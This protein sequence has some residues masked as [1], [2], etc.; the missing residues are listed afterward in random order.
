LEAIVLKKRL[1]ALLLVL[2]FFVGFAAPAAYA[3]QDTTALQAANYL[4]SFGL[5]RGTDRGYELERAGTRAEALVMLI[6]LLGDEDYALA[7]YHWH[8]FDDVPAWA[9]LYVGYA[10]AVGLTNGISATKFGS[11]EP[12]SAAMFITF[13]LR[14]LRYDDDLNDF[15]WDS[16]WTLSDKIGITYGKYRS[17]SSFTRG[18][19]CY[20]SFNALNTRLKYSTWTLFESLKDHGAI[21]SNVYYPGGTR[22]WDDS[23]YVDEHNIQAYDGIR[24]YPIYV[25]D[26]SDYYANY[27]YEH[28]DNGIVSCYWGD[29]GIGTY[30]DP[31]TLYITPLKPGTIAIYITFVDGTSNNP[32]ELVVLNVHVY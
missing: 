30:D 26:D 16:P 21:P 31:Y 15:K 12:A 11:N 19:M 8:P 25:W 9:S 13:V 14:A 28:A 1:L 20:V 32:Y 27:W 18:D 2:T 23:I 5:F 17:G 29:D 22:D 24:D 4:N 6:R 7:H 3:A 10:Y